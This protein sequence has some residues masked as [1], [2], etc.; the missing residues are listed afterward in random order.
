MT[1]MKYFQVKYSL[2]Y[3]KLYFVISNVKNITIAI[4]ALIALTISTSIYKLTR[5]LTNATFKVAF[6]HKLNVFISLKILSYF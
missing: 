6:L 3:F 1:T 4:E 2:D 5:S